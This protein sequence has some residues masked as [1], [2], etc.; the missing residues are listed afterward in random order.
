MFEEEEEE[1]EFDLLS[2]RGATEEGGL[3]IKEDE[4]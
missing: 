1:E 3:S 2:E 4:R